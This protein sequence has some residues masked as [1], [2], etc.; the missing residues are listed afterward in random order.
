MAIQGVVYQNQK[1][2]AEDHA[3]LFQMFITDGILS[4]CGISKLRNVLT[5]TSG[6][7]ILAGRLSK[8]I[9]SEQI[10]IPDTIRSTTVRLTGVIDLTQAA[11]K[12][13]FHQFSF[14]LDP[15]SNGTYP[16]LR[17]ENINTD[18]NAHYYEVE[19]AILTIDGDGNISNVEVKIGNSEGGSGDG[20]GSGDITGDSY[21]FTGP[22][23]SAVYLSDETH[24]EL[25]LLASGDLTFTK[26]PGQVDVFAVGPGGDGD[27][28]SFPGATGAAG[29]GGNGGEAITFEN[30]TLT[31]NTKYQIKID[32]I[33]T[34]ETSGLPGIVAYGGNNSSWSSDKGKVGGQGAITNQ[35]SGAQ[36]PGNG[37]NGVLAFGKA[38]TLYEPGRLYGASAGGGAAS[39]DTQ[40]QGWTS[41]NGGYGATTGSGYGGSASDNVGAAGSATV[42]NTGAAGG[43]AAVGYGGYSGARLYGQPGKGA[44]GIMIISGKFAA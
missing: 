25:V 28:A 38:D 23:G 40:N 42:Q 35:S 36:N 37:T 14:R 30:V 33:G 22:A 34:G 12:T 9:G 2:S 43:G 13:E 16:A 21:T 32:D 41:Q 7:F 20:G 19:W 1:V 31:R 26:N 17:T 5:I 4:G 11:T 8:I 29:K 10:T 6:M 39:H 15:E 44:S 24:W 3:A 27:S 18:N